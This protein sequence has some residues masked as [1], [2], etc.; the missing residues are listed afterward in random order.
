MKETGNNQRILIDDLVSHIY[1]LLERT[2]YISF[3]KEQPDRFISI[4]RSFYRYHK[5]IEIQPN[6]VSKQEEKSYK[7]WIDKKVYYIRDINILLDPSGLDLDL[8]DIFSNS[9]NPLFKKEIYKY[10]R[11]YYQYFSEATAKNLIDLFITI[12]DGN[13]KFTSLKEGIVLPFMYHVTT[14][15]TMYIIA[16]QYTV[17]LRKSVV[18]YLMINGASLIHYNFHEENEKEYTGNKPVEEFKKYCE[19]YLEKNGI[20]YIL[21]D[22]DLDK[23]NRENVYNLIKDESFYNLHKRSLLEHYSKIKNLPEDNMTKH[24]SDNKNNK[25]EDLIYNF[26]KL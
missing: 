2:K 11:N 24:P 12:C 5:G 23:E 16:K 20:N 10:H 15:S 8:D 17:P 1:S 14:N 6:E 19:K 21:S 13:K 18:C 9:D 22:N 7:N 3:K 26:Y 4:V 25:L